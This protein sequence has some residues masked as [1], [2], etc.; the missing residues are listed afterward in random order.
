MLI[1]GAGAAGMAAAI[2]AARRGTRVRLLERND[3]AGKKIRVSGNG[4]CNIGN[5]RIRPERYHSG[6]RVFVRKVLEGY[7]APRIEA[8]LRSLGL[9][10]EE[11]EEGKL[12]PMGRQAASVVRLLT[13]ECQRLGVELVTGCQV[14]GITHEQDRFLVESSR[15]DF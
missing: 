1:V 5:R 12:F 11:E 15:E 8:F 6:D 10:P 3:E 14:T 2:T 13:R 4:R 9:E 7:D